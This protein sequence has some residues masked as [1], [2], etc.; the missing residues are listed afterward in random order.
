MFHY[1]FCIMARTTTRTLPQRRER[2]L[3]ELA[4]IGD[5]RQGSLNKMYRKC[6]KSRCR[7]STKKH[8]GH[9][10]TW[11]WSRHAD[12]RTRS[13]IIPEA[14]VPE[15]RRQVD[16]YHKFRELCRELSEVSSLLC[17]ARRQQAERR[18]ASAYRPAGP[19]ACSGILPVAIAALLLCAAPFSAMAEEREV[20]IIK[21]HPLGDKGLAA[22]VT[23]LAGEELDRVRG[24]NLGTILSSQPGIHQASYGT[25]VGRPVVHGLAGPRVRI[26]QDRLDTMDVSVISADHAVAVESFI[27]E[28]VEV[29]RGP[30]I[31]LYGSGAIGGAVNV[32]TGRIPQ[33]PAEG[34]Y[35]ATEAR[36]TSAT[37]GDALAFKLNG[38]RGDFAWHLDGAT[39]DGD[40]Y[41]I[42]GYAESAQLRAQEA[43]HDD[44]DD[45]H[46]DHEE[47]EARDKLPGSHFDTDSIA[48]GASWHGKWG[49]AGLSLSRLE[50]EYG[51]PGPH[52]HHHDEHDDDNGEGHDEDEEEGNATLD[53]EQTRTDL[54]VNL[55]EP[56]SGVHRLNMRFGYSDYKHTEYEPG[57]HAGTK[58][59]NDAW[60]ARAEFHHDASA[61]EGVAG[62]Q[63]A[64]RD[65]SAIGAEVFVPPVITNS[66][67]VFWVGRR[68]YETF[69]LEAGMRLER[70]SHNPA[71]GGGEHHHGDDDDDD[72]HEAGGDKDFTIH[73]VSA[74]ALVPLGDRLDLGL[75]ASHSSRAPVAE[76]L[77]ANGPHLVTNTYE[78]G[79]AELSKERAASISM[80]LQYATPVWD[81]AVAAYFTRFSDYVYWEATGRTVNHE[82]HDCNH[83][84]EKDTNYPT[85]EDDT[86]KNAFRKQ[87][88]MDH[89]D[90]YGLREERVAQEDAEFFGIDGEASVRIASW[91][92]GEARLRGKFDY[93]D[94]K[95]SV[96]GDDRL[97][98][99]PPLRYG[100]GL[101]ARWGA[102]SLSVDYMRAED[103]DETATYELPTDG[104]D[105]LSVHA[106]MELPAGEGTTLEIF[107][108]GKNLTDD[109]QRLHT[110]HIK[111]YA[112]QPG[113]SF[114]VGARLKF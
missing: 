50:A 16:E 52:E 104:Y 36:H 70:V 92:G 61:W 23:S 12:G 45:D 107:L 105:D 78:I 90:D 103:Q 39:K 100:I 44:D 37:G 24:V 80:R 79:D 26:M 74:G 95:L 25:V 112:P 1:R 69:D 5:F 35:G 40:D 71:A 48:G 59:S 33:K 99:I 97:P 21:A 32:H 68:P 46:D 102:A 58:F 85:A 51:L 86:A 87:Y 72:E 96:S 101:S 60:E 88:C 17:E 76:E 62:L 81:A 49:F 75:L 20:L 14:D 77:Y 31:L 106:S 13:S 114:E 34:L 2:L 111:D 66:A 11:V 109:E 43:E 82:G 108:H 64:Y 6:G 83:D 93:V 7:C 56:F 42:P 10:P 67:G 110:S 19:G 30:S 94:A 4:S 73:A 9:G 38:G 28:E 57:G 53:M 3:K 89:G 29:L 22:P 91:T 55:L 65:F 98:R 54:E 15:V 41:D 84:A 63:Y 113:R 18:T 47:E 27:A 8:P